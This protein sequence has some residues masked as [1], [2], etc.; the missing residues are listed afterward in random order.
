MKIVK[1]VIGNHRG[2]FSIVLH[3][4]NIAEHLSDDEV[5]VIDLINNANAYEDDPTKNNMWSQYFISQPYT[6]D[7]VTRQVGDINSGFCVSTRLSQSK[8][9]YYKNIINKTLIIQPHIIEK[10]LKFK[11]ENFGNNKILG[12][13]IRGTD[14]FKD[15]TRLKLS[16][17]Y[18]KHKID[19]YL[20]KEGFDKIFVCSDQKHTIDRL[21]NIYGDKII[22]YPSLEYPLE[23]HQHTIF[24]KTIP[25]E[26]YIRGEDVL[27][28]SLLLSQTDFLLRGQSNITTFSIIYNPKLRYCDIDV[29]FYAVRPVHE[30]TTFSVNCQYENES[31]LQP[32]FEQLKEIE[33]KLYTIRDQAIL[34]KIIKEYL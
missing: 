20:E 6:E 15:N 33:E 12:V 34:D 18:Y 29:P 9:N 5:L 8:R 23:G 24:K 14:A 27:I 2:F 1:T 11:E 25:N 32:F 3:Y 10:F 30:S 16:F 31:D 26:G 21:K 19:L 13:H 22:T 17:D 28:E 7:E 4:L